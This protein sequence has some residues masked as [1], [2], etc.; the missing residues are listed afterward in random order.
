LKEINLEAYLEALQVEAYLEVLQVEVSL[1]ALPVEDYFQDN[2]KKFTNIIFSVLESG[3][4][5]S[6]L[7]NRQGGGLFSSTNNGA[8]YGADARTLLETQLMGGGLDL[9]QAQ[10]YDL[11][12]V[13]FGNT[14]QNY[15]LFG[16]TIGSPDSL[17]EIQNKYETERDT[18]SLNIIRRND[19]FSYSPFDKPSFSR[20]N[21]L[22][23]CPDL[24]SRLAHRNKL[25]SSK[26]KDQPLL[27]GRKYSERQSFLDEEE[28]EV[29]KK[30]HFSCNG[31]PIK[32]PIDLTSWLSIIF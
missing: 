23:I 25:L 12:R 18:P 22:D 26:K 31:T 3:G 1:V 28:E 17:R 9:Q 8:Q 6:G 10:L 19:K 4:L 16:K 29:C 27:I 30:V 5:F 21:Y 13:S 2:V 24:E 20:R 7:N 11:I 14:Q 32:K 15:N